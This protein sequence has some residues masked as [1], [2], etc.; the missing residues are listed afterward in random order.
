MKKTERLKIITVL[1]FIIF[2]IS[3][4]AYASPDDDT[5]RP[6]HVVELDGAITA[7]QKN[8][9]QRQVAIALDADAQLFLLVMN[10]P[11]GLVDATLEI[12]ELFLNAELPVAVLVAPSGAIAGS[13]GAFIIVS[14][15]IAA[16]AP[17]TTVGAAQPIAITPEGASEA[18]EKTTI[19]YSTHLR[20]MA[21][22]K[23]RPEDI[24]EK[25]VTENLTL[26]AREA[27]EVGIIDY[28]AGNVTELL[29]AIDGTAVVKQG[30]VYSLQTVNAPL[31]YDDMTMSERMQNWLSD[32]QI[33]FLVLMAGLMGIY[34][35]FNAPGTFVPEVGGAIL[36]VLG[37]YGIGLFDINTTGVV[38][39][40]L[41]FG[42]IAAEIFTSGFGV[43]GIGGAISL[44]AGAVMLPTEPLMAR[45][46]YGAFLVTVVGTVLGLV[47]IIIFVA[48]RVIHSRRTWTGGSSYFNPPDTGV[49]VKELNPEGMIKARGELWKAISENGT[50]IPAQR[51]VEVVRAE[52][53]KLYVRLLEKNNE[54]A[55]KF[56]EGKSQA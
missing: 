11:G 1:L 39:L 37:I 26:D 34:L 51:E 31:V 49:T 17:G 35:G 27:L 22:E 21:R 5:V 18:D 15:D 10:T 53:L 7:G 41:G 19:F 2:I 36:L 32:P 55:A 43:L 47:I 25:F 38:L 29:N 44:V 24:A 23:N 28:L 16:M 4:A 13:A 20:S 8:F 54:E 45:D 56:E 30:E 40:L 12:N 3:T 14:S 42:L 6:V 9:L 48:Q 46:W 50:T 33:S 52:T